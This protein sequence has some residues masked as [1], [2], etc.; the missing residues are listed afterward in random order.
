MPSPS[1]LPS[2]LDRIANGTHTDA[3]LATFRR[4][5]D[6]GNV[7]VEGDVTDSVIIT[8]YGNEVRIEK[9]TSLDSLRELLQEFLPPREPEPTNDHETTQT[10]F[11][12]HTAQMISKQVNHYIKENQ[13]ALLP[14]KTGSKSR[15]E[16]Y[17]NMIE[18]Y[19]IQEAQPDFGEWIGGIHSIANDEQVS[20][21]LHELA[22]DLE[23]RIWELH[24][25]FYEDREYHLNSKTHQGVYKLA[26]T[27]MIG[28]QEKYSL[29]ETQQVTDQ[30]LARLRS[31]IFEIGKVVG[32]LRNMHESKVS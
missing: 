11:L 26:V 1:A 29:T 8:G 30:Y 5:I 20:Q 18:I 6:T 2:I 14:L 27:N 10:Q 12:F 22:I 13:Q 4:A 31:I 25:L 15:Q 24:H 23:D 3:D 16:I 21:H 7:K 9:G 32:E 19:T 28:N 17:E